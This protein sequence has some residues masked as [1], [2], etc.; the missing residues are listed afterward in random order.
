[1]RWQSLQG[2][3][4]L[5]REAESDKNWFHPPNGNFRIRRSCIFHFL[6]SQTNMSSYTYVEFPFFA[7]MLLN[8]A[9]NACK[10]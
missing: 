5:K 2:E 3:K 9:L 7:I 6:C 4:E 10:N 1:M 8:V